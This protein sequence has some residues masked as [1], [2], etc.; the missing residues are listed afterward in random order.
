MNKKEDPGTQADPVYAAIDAHR[1]AHVAHEAAIDREFELEA[2]LPQEKRQSRVDGNGATMS[3]TDDPLWMMSELAVRRASDAKF[4]AACDLLDVRPTTIAGI[5]ALS[6]YAVDH[7]DAGNN[8]PDQVGDVDEA[9]HEREQ[10]W[11]Y[12][13]L[14]S[15]A[16]SLEA[17]ES[18]GRTDRG[19]D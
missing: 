5:V 12:F 7:M 14:E 6:K 8:W 4:R 17:I 19:S 11:A 3:A 2:R 18:R 10:P 13:L 1:K 15:I 9:G 16:K